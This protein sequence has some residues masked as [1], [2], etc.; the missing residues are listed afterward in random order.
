MQQNQKK[1]IP[2]RGLSGTGP[3]PLLLAEGTKS[4]EIRSWDHSYRGIVFFHTARFNKIHL[5]SYEYWD[6]QLEE[7]PDQALLGSGILSEI[8]HYDTPEH[9]YA[10][11][12]KHCWTG[13]PDYNYV[14]KECYNGYPPFG[15]VFVDPILFDKPVLDVPGSHKYWNPLNDRQKAGFHQAITILRSLK[16]DEPLATRPD[17]IQPKTE[18]EQLEGSG[19]I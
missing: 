15:H 3:F 5:P 9:W 13:D 17:P 12:N 2:P 4:I 1:T 6:M 10:D 18:E 7:C 19:K 14:V 11:L 16:T 8:V